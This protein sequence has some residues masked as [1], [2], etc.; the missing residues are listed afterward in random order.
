MNSI[1]YEIERTLLECQRR[2]PGLMPSYEQLKALLEDAKREIEYL[3]DRIV[4]LEA[5]DEPD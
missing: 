1:A 3:E 5:E 2:K 4:D